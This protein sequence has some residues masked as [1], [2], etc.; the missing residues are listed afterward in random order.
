MV[1]HDFFLFT[2]LHDEVVCLICNKVV[3]VPKKVQFASLQ[4]FMQSK[5]LC[6]WL[7]AQ[8]RHLRP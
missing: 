8:R 2:L 6:S 3:F 5:V 4:N 1:E 7:E